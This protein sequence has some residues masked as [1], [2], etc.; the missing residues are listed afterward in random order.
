MSHLGQVWLRKIACVISI[1]MFCK[2]T[3]GKLSQIRPV[4]GGPGLV[5][6]YRRLREEGAHSPT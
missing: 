6:G 5:H 3:H 1:V 4:Y 2:V